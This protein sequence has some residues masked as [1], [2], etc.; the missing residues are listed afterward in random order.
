M[1]NPNETHDCVFCQIAIKELPTDFILEED[2]YVAFKDIA[3][4]APVHIVLSSKKHF[5]SLNEAEDVDKELVGNM[6]FGAR[7]LA[8]SLGIDESGYRI[9]INTGKE[10]G[11]T[12]N[13]FHMHL[14]GGTQ[15][16][17]MEK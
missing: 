17:G 9:V 5:T 16:G 12:M 4:K 2:D 7:K 13:H 11:Q 15:L 6:V 3:P 8:K 10:G 1:P 14:L